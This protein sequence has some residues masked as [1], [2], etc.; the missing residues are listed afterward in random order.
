MKI[1]QINTVKTL[2]EI[3]YIGLLENY[4]KKSIFEEIRSFI[5]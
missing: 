4:A 2:V 1:L 5:K 3:F